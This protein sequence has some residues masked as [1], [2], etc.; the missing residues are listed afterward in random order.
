MNKFVTG[1]V[2][3][4]GM[5]GSLGWGTTAQAKTKWTTGSPKQLRGAWVQLRVK[6]IGED[7][8]IS[9]NAMMLAKSSVLIMTDFGGQTYG[10]K[11]LA[12]RFNRGT[13]DLRDYAGPEKTWNYTKITRHGKKMTLQEYGKRKLGKPFKQVTAKAVHLKY[14]AKASAALLK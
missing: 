12:Y 10:G 6:H 8:D 4:L 11:H 7:T 1:A 14:N 5:V 3:V 2:V 13:Y 9:A